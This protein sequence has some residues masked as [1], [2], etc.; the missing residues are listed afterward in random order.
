MKI[1]NHN[2]IKIISGGE[3]ARMDLNL[4]GVPLTYVPMVLGELQKF[5]AGK[6]NVTQFMDAVNKAGLDTSHFTAN[7]Y[8]A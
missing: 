7:L 6:G 1:L 3:H 4:S 5:Q 8:Y 2:E